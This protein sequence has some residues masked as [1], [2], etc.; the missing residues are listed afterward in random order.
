LEQGREP[1][2]FL[3]VTRTVAASPD[4]IKADE[5][6]LKAAGLGTETAPRPT[7]RKLDEK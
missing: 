4:A 5:E 6:T 7:A 3:I 2:L 1:R